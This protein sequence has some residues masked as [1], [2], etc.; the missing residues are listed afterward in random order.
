[1]HE[2]GIVFH[3]ADV[4]EAVGTERGLTRVS[5]VTLSLGEVSGVIDSYLDDCWR[6]TA[7]RSDLL[8]GSELEI[9]R[10]PAVTLCRT[11]DHEYETVR[12]GRTCPR[13]G[14]DDTYL[15]TG[16]EI[17]IKQIEAR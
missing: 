12:F 10:I 6:W 4:I 13:C 14:G 5:K 9:E 16:D 15:V 8:R 17:E 1:M 7:D 3:I 2:L 11:C